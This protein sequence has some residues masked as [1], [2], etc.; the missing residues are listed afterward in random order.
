M[1][2]VIDM[3]LRIM[4]FSMM[5]VMSMAAFWPGVPS[6]ALAGWLWRKAGGGRNGWRNGVW[7]LAY[8]GG[9]GA[10]LALNGIWRNPSASK[11]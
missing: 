6:A 10:I 7:R 8:G 1:T 2:C 9:N 11:C 5:M 4:L 3:I